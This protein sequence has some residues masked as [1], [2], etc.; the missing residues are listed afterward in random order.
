MALRQVD[1]GM[2]SL[3]NFG[4]RRGLMSI[5]FA[6]VH[7]PH[8]IRCVV[9]VRGSRVCLDCGCALLFIFVSQLVFQD[10]KERFEMKKLIGVSAGLCL[11]FGC[12]GIAAAQESI[13]PPPKVLVIQRE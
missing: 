8:R 12:V 10:R 4:G 7:S 3:E 2:E 1:G 6:A 9:I 5:K 13:S 11:L